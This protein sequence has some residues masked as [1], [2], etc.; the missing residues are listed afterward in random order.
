MPTDLERGGNF[1]R[2]FNARGGLRTVY[3]P[4]TTQLINNGATSQRMPF[5]NNAIPANRIDPT[6]AIIMKDIWAP[7]GPGDDI[8]GLVIRAR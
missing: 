4:M 2:T 6:S 3:D 8:T 5:P 1:S 7:N